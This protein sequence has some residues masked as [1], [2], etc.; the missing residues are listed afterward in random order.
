VNLNFET[1]RGVGIFLKALNETSD[2]TRLLI[3]GNVHLAKPGGGG[4]IG[5]IVFNDIS[6]QYELVIA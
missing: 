2:A 1:L 4:V 5:E 6:K 3:G